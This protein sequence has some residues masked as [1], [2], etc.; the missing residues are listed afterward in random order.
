MAATTR[1]A[2]VVFAFVLITPSS[3]LVLIDAVLYQGWSRVALLYESAV[4]ARQHRLTLE[5]TTLSP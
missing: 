3:A 5:V 2:Y 4:P 1:S